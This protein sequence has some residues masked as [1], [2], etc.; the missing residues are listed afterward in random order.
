MVMQLKSCGQI[1]L[2]KPDQPVQVHSMV[3][4]KVEGLGK[5]ELVKYQF[6]DVVAHE[7]IRDWLPDPKVVLFIVG[8]AVGCVDFA[9]IDSSAIQVYGDTVDIVLPA[10]EICYTRIDHNESR[11]FDTQYTFWEEAELVDAAYEAA[12][13][14][15]KKAA[16][17]SDLMAN[18]EAQAEVLLKPLL[19][20]LSGKSVNIRF[21]QPI[22]ALRPASVRD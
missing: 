13:V 14:E 2:T 15:L 1:H 8:E 22:P 18:A 11:V 19:S 3:L 21:R 20:Q 5:M 7:V 12:E 4:E 16:E 17:R 10:P 9:A 6:Q